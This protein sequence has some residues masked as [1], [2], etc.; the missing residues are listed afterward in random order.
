[1]EIFYAVLGIIVIAG[2]AFIYTW[3]RCSH[4]VFVSNNIGDIRCVSC[5]KDL[6]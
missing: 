2:L 4:E 1:M 5:G 3:R 6:T